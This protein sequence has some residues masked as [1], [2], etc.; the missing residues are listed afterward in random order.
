MRTAYKKEGAPLRTRAKMLEKSDS[1]RMSS[2]LR[3]EI[4]HN[5]AAGE[6]EA[7]LCTLERAMKS[8]GGRGLVRINMAR[9]REDCFACVAR[10]RVWHRQ[11]AEMQATAT[12]VSKASVSNLGTFLHGSPH[13]DARRSRL[14]SGWFFLLSDRHLIVSDTQVRTRSS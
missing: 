9:M 14:C 5:G 3:K 2:R 8:I 6:P 1:L 10:V 11:S 7:H 13:C 12:T 4:Q